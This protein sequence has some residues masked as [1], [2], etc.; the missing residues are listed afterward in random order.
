MAQNGAVEVGGEFPDQQQVM[1]NSLLDTTPIVDK[2]TLRVKGDGKCFMY[3]VLYQMY[4][5]EYPDGKGSI[6]IDGVQINKGDFYTNPYNENLP[7][8]QLTEDIFNAYLAI[9]PADKHNEITAPAVELMG[10]FLAHIFKRTIQLTVITKADV[11]N[12]VEMY[13]AGDNKEIIQVATVFGRHHITLP[14]Q[15]NGSDVKEERNWMSRPCDTQMEIEP[16]G[17]A[18]AKYEKCAA[19]YVVAYHKNEAPEEKVVVEVKEVNAV[20]DNKSEQKSDKVVNVVEKDKSGE[21]ASDK[22]DPTEVEVQ[23]NAFYRDIAQY[24]RAKIKTHNVLESAQFGSS[25]SQDGASENVQ[26]DS[27]SGGELNAVKGENLKEA[28]M[29]AYGSIQDPDCKKAIG[30]FKESDGEED[31]DFIKNNKGVIRKLYIYDI[32]KKVFE[33]NKTSFEEYANSGDDATVFFQDQVLFKQ[34]AKYNVDELAK[35]YSKSQYKEEQGKSQITSSDFKSFKQ[36][37]E[38]QVKTH[39]KNSHA[40]IIKDLTPYNDIIKEIKKFAKENKEILEKYTG[41]TGNDM[42]SIGVVGRIYSDLK[43]QAKPR[44]GITK[45]KEREAIKN[46]LGE[47]KKELAKKAAER[48]VLLEKLNEHREHINKLEES[49][50]NNKIGEQRQSSS[51]VVSTTLFDNIKEANI[52]GLENTVKQAENLL[53]KLKIINQIKCQTDDWGKID[54]WYEVANETLPGKCDTNGKCTTVQAGKEY[55]GLR[56]YVAKDDVTKMSLEKLKTILQDVQNVNKR[57]NALAEKRYVLI[58]DVPYVYDRAKIITDC[59]TYPF[60]GIESTLLNSGKISTEKAKATTPE[61]SYT[62]YSTALESLKTELNVYNTGKNAKN[63]IANSFEGL[64]TQL[65][66]LKCKNFT[67]Q[68]LGQKFMQFMSVAAKPGS[69]SC[70]TTEASVMKAAK[71]DL[72]AT[73]NHMNEFKKINEQYKEFAKLKE[74]NAEWN[75]EHGKKLVALITKYNKL[76]DSAQKLGTF[77]KL[78]GKESGDARA[79]RFTDIQKS[80]LHNFSKDV[81]PTITYYKNKLNKIEIPKIASASG[82]VQGGGR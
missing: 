42:R 13:V 78:A 3:A 50:A 22:K 67:K 44:K 41:L 73:I 23:E 77:E 9:H 61:F 34:Y 69:S 19:K 28:V 82:K 4:C 54:K 25:E 14:K 35:T 58:K 75:E 2:V 63:G 5:N 45:E 36:N 17:D 15:L 47:F 32:A 70:I 72:E 66:D 1:I 7:L 81:V 57:I 6:T 65:T 51:A 38:E 53:H 10:P 48:N 68:S 59:K 55:K 12:R 16:V 33:E 40:A 80:K 43:T 20:E 8:P 79:K 31:G 60:A 26:S 11:K 49:I 21:E 39:I 18:L 62:D 27:E 29:D 64:R 24:F 56:D 71:N 76:C 37:L 74:A 52:A 30:E 46:K